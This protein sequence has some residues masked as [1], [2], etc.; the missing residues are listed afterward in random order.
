LSPVVAVEEAAKA[1]A[2][3]GRS[4]CFDLILGAGTALPD[5]VWR[6]QVLDSVVRLAELSEP[7]LRK[8]IPEVLRTALAR[9]REEWALRVPILCAWRT[10]SRELRGDLD[11]L[12]TAGP[13]EYEGPLQ[14]PAAPDGEAHGRFHLARKVLSLWDEQDPLTRGRLLVAFGF[15]EGTGVEKTVR[16]RLADLA[17]SL[18]PADRREL[19]GFAAWYEQR[20]ADRRKQRGEPPAPSSR[21]DLGDFVRELS[22]SN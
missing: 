13:L 17:R 15:E 4:E 3:R 10:D 8:R 22:A 6:G 19:A 14:K 9:E 12:A 20:L 16:R 2:R 21:T 1:L 7:S 11:R 18:T 5:S